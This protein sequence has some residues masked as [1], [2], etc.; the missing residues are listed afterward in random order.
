MY[1]DILI[2]IL[3]NFHGVKHTPGCREKRDQL[4]ILTWW[5]WKLVWIKY[6]AAITISSNFFRNMLK[7]QTC[8]HR[9]IKNVFSKYNLC[10]LELLVKLNLQNWSRSIERIMLQKSSCIVYT[11]TTYID[12]P[13]SYCALTILMQF[14]KTN[15]PPHFF[16][17][18]RKNLN[19]GQ[20]KGS[21]S[22]SHTT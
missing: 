13:T 14:S 20:M 4:V 19:M 10:S 16:L 22:F 15:E 21:W 18:E 6:Q 5:F 1:S 17:K 3:L 9:P 12:A 2:L 11:P 8:A 7:C